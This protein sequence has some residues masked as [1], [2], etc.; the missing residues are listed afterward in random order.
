MCLVLPLCFSLLELELEPEEVLPQKSL[1]LVLQSNHGCQKLETGM[2]TISGPKSSESCGPKGNCT[3]YFSI[4]DNF[5]DD[6]LSIY[7]IVPGSSVN[8][9]C[10]SEGQHAWTSTAPQFT[11]GLDKALHI[12]GSLFYCFFETQMK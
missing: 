1:Y 12:V 7:S 3:Q 11:K 9:T 8:L 6:N 5:V 10:L 2:K 4:F